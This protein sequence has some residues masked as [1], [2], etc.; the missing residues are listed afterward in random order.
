MQVELKADLHD[1]YRVISVVGTIGGCI[2]LEKEVSVEELIKSFVI[3]AQKNSCGECVPCRVG[4]KWM[5]ELLGRYL[6]GELSSEEK[7]LLKSLAE[8]IGASSRCD[9]GKV[10]GK[11]VKY[12]LEYGLIE[13]K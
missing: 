1:L 12:A 8:N 5:E 4:T 2:F 10:A 13:E 11:I 9:L 6:K 3:Y 7:E